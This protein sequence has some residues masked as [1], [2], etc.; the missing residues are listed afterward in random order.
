MAAKKR[1]KKSPKKSSRTTSRKSAKK[2]PA[3]K[4]AGKTKK[5]AKKVGTQ[6]ALGGNPVHT[7]G[8]L[9]KVGAKL[10]SFTL[11]TGDLQDVS[12]KDFA[13]TRVIFNIFPSIDTN[14]CA[15]STRTFNSLVGS[16]KNTEVWCVSADLPFAQKRFC[17]AEGLNNV[18]TASTF[19]SDFG[20]TFGV[21]L[22]DSVLKGVLARA[23]VVADEKGK[24]LH[25]EMVSEIAKE[26]NYDAAVKALG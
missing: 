25:T 11:T 1:A 17:G 2:S 5:S 24:I 4:K 19:R 6:V 9:P 22:R 16:L 10:P 14:T 7:V 23:I 26:P 3:K 15:T 13:G 21:T 18:K 12:N 8:A 20:K